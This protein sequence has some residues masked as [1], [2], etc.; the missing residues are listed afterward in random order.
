MSKP[1]MARSRNDFEICADLLPKAREIAK[2]IVALCRKVH[3]REPTGGGCK[4]FYS[5]AVWRARGE[6]YGLES[7]LI[8]VHDGGDLAPMCNMDYEDFE[9]YAQLRDTLRPLGVYLENC[10]SWY[11]AV[12]PLAPLPVAKKP[13]GYFC[14]HCGSRDTRMLPEV[15]WSLTS[16][17]NCTSFGGNATECVC[18]GCGRSFWL[19]PSKE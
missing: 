4:A 7:L 10:T 3:K 15:A 17:D 12:Y 18:Q 8:L 6:E 14:P 5:P 9:S 2:A 19:F 16:A 1:I 11:S 13:V